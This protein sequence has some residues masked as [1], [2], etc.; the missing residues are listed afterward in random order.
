LAPFRSVPAETAGRKLEF[1]ETRYSSRRGGIE[2][3]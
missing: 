2:F 1:G 3:P